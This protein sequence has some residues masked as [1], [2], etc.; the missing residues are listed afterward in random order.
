MIFRRQRTEEVGI[1]LTPL[2]DVVFLL[3]IFFMVSTTFTK[4]T[5][6]DLELPTSS[7]TATTVEGTPIEI[8]V[9]AQGSYLV[10]GQALVQSTLESLTRAVQLEMS[11]DNKQAGIIIVADAKAPHQAV[12]YALDAAGQL[13]ISQVQLATRISGEAP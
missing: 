8:V 4:E 10:N 12:V 3:L 6:M 11:G 13:G 5:H 1:N 7:S 2:I 9:S